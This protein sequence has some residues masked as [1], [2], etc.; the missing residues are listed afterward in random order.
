MSEMFVI[1]L[2]NLKE[3][4]NKFTNNI[5]NLYDCDIVQISKLTQQ[6]DSNV[7]EMQKLVSFYFN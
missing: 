5:K 6:A 7:T 3:M 4:H 1:F 2:E